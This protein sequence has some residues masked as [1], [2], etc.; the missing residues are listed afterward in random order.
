MMRPLLDPSGNPTKPH[1][2]LSTAT[3]GDAFVNIETGINFGRAAGAIPFLPPT[4][5]TKYPEYADYVTPQALYDA[6]GEKT[7]NEVLIENYEVEGDYKLARRPAGPTCGVNYDTSNPLLCPDKPVPDPT[8][9]ADTLYDADWVSE[10]GNMYDAQHPT[11]PLRLGRIAGMHVDP[12]NPATLAAAWAPRIKGVPFSSDT[13]AWD[14]SAMV[15][16]HVNVY[17]EARR[18]AHVGRR[19]RLQKALGRRQL[20]RQPPRPLLPERRHHDV[21][22]LS[23]PNSHE[24]L[25]QLNGPVFA[26]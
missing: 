6:F 11:S 13:N 3:V 16:G 24:C 21:Y 25:D 9:C 15:L 20:R 8:T 1:A 22:Y 12:T 10:G 7:P 5:L 18:P 4:A 26:P 17:I 23:H 14:A 2:L 19:R